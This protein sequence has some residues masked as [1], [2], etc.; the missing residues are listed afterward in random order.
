MAEI[1]KLYFIINKDGSRHGNKSWIEYPFKLKR[2]FSDGS[3]YLLKNGDG[4]EERQYIQEGTKTLKEY[5][6]N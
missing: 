2:I 4:W 3:Y 1:G 5:Y 6:G